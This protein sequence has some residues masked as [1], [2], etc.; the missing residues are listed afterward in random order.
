[1]IRENLPDDLKEYFNDID[2]VNPFEYGVCE[3]LHETNYFLFK[4]TLYRLKDL[5]QVNSKDEPIYVY[6]LSTGKKRPTVNCTDILGG[7]MKWKDEEKRAVANYPIGFINAIACV[8]FKRW[9]AFVVCTANKKMFSDGDTAENFA[10]SLK[11][12]AYNNIQAVRFVKTL[13]TTDCDK[14]YSIGVSLGALTLEGVFGIEDS[15]KKAVIILGGYP[16]TSIIAT[17]DE[18]M[19]KGFFDRMIQLYGDSNTA[20]QKIREAIAPIEDVYTYAPGNDIMQI[21]MEDGDTS[22]PSAYQKE[23]SLQAN[24]AEIVKLPYRKI[25]AIKDL[26]NGHYQTLLYYPYLIYRSLKFLGR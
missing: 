19:V 23:Y 7:V 13:E 11:N 15:Y 18:G 1:M 14:I 3:K 2:D 12:V 6:Y 5:Y 17:S 9:N 4:I 21:R 8:L 22:V 25:F 20:I 26:K 24:V 16:L 10:L